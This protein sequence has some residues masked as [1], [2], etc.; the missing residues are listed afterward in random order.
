M[1]S[2]A[3][4][5]TSEA[6]IQ[7]IEILSF[8]RHNPTA[9]KGNLE[10]KRET[11][12]LVV[13][14]VKPLEN[15]GLLP[16]GVIAVAFARFWYALF[17]GQIELEGEHALSVNTDEWLNALYLVSGG[18]SPRRTGRTG[19]IYRSL[20]A[21]IPVRSTRAHPSSGSH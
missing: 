12:A 19:L 10:A 2:R 20:N 15:K 5:G 7:R 16:E 21:S 6:R 4:D 18:D 17:F 9:S 11:A 1:T 13:A 3:L 8:A 14:R